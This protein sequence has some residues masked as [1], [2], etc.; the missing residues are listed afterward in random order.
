MLR[1]P[2][3]NVQNLKISVCI[4]P[5]STVEATKELFREDRWQPFYRRRDV[6]SRIFKNILRLE[7]DQGQG[8]KKARRFL[9]KSRPGHLYSREYSR[10]RKSAGPLI[11]SKIFR[12]N[13]DRPSRQPSSSSASRAE[14][15]GGLWSSSVRCVAGVGHSASHPRQALLCASLR[16]HSQWADERRGRAPSSRV[17]TR[18][19]QGAHGTL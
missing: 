4:D 11:F 8:L 1:K 5:K 9:R 14:S 13:V 3:R 19:T 2:L 17:Q 15:K 12:N 10:I 6:T 16:P 7:V 18:S